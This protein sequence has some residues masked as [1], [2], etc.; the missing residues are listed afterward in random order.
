MDRCYFINKETFEI[1]KEHPEFF[2]CDPQIANAISILNK[3]GYQ[4]IASCES[5]YEIKEYDISYPKEKRITG[6]YIL[7]QEKYHFL[8][9]PQGFETEVIEGKTNLFHTIY[10]YHDNGKYKHRKEF[11]IEK[12]QYINKLTEWAKNLPER[13]R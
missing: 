11:E 2:T 10:Y 3:K 8:T 5:H 7:F 13:E 4:T 1:D 9:I 6:I 12:K